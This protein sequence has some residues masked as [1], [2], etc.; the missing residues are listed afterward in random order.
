MV[1]TVTKSELL[2][3]KAPPSPKDSHRDNVG[4]GTY[5][6]WDILD[7]S[8]SRANS[9]GAGKRPLEGSPTAPSQTNKVIRLDPN[10][11]FQDMKNH[12]E[13]LISARSSLME[14]KTL[15]DEKDIYSAGP[16]G[17][18]MGKLI[19][20]ISTLID[21]Q[22]GLTSSI[23]DF[24]NASTRTPPPEQGLYTNG[25][26]SNQAGRE[27]ANTAGKN[28]MKKP[29]SA[30]ELLQRKVKQEVIKAEKS[31]ILFDL[32]LGSVPVINKDTLSTKVT[33]AIHA[34]AKGGP[35]VAA[36]NYSAGEASEILDDILT[37]ANLEFLGNGSKKYF[38]PRDGSDPQNGKFC[39][40]PAKLT[41]KTKDERIRAEQ[42]IRKI[43]KVRCSVPYPKKLRGL[44]NALIQEGRTKS[45]GNYIQVKVDTEKMKLTARASI[46]NKGN[47]KY[48]WVDLGIDQDI[49]GDVLDKVQ[50]NLD[51]ETMDSQV[52]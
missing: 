48:E 46:H 27:R 15:G 8:R 20:V 32:D 25:E 43:C 45:P 39:T 5:N 16:M 13:K 9:V 24:C 19:S 40:I 38:N 28:T 10:K 51:P 50:V 1:K 14:A 37:C 11:I 49:P 21:H 17:S 2:K 26:N 33:Y 12:E 44:I 52:S 7:P 29:P 42:A 23:I 6:R 4:K 35:E 3:H 47:N 36:G 41:F 30:E 22:E 34:A 31:T 18:V